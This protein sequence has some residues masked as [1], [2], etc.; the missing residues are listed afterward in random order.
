M[1]SIS[2][3]ILPRFWN[4]FIGYLFRSTFD[5]KTSEVIMN[6]IVSISLIKCMHYLV[7]ATNLWVNSAIILIHRLSRRPRYQL[8]R[9]G[10][11]SKARETFAVGLWRPT[12][13]AKKTKLFI[14]LC[15]I[16]KREL[17]ITI[18]S[19]RPRYNRGNCSI[20]FVFSP[21]F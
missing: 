11:K 14:D 12:T 20:A 4:E 17:K 9:H 13:E 16:E 19:H 1:L 15:E 21:T 3:K 18:N 7:S 2:H 6:S 5:L 8:Y 10:L